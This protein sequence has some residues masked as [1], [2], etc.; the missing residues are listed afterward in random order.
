VKL[1]VDFHHSCLFESHQLT[2]GDRFGFEVYA[3]YGMDW[4]NEWIWSFEREWHGD[5]VAR[6]YL[7]GIFAGGTLDDGIM[8]VADQ[9]HPGRVIKGITLERAR[10]ERWDLVLSSV[11]SN[12]PGFEKF[13]REHGGRWGIHVGNQWG[14]EAWS[15]S[16]EFAILTTT[17]P[18]PG[19]IPHVVVHQEFSLDD[20]HYEPPAE[21]GPI[22]SFV[23]CFPEMTSEYQGNFVPLAR[24]APEFDWRVFGAYGTAPLDEFEGGNIPSDPLEGTMM[25][26][27]GVIWH[28]KA[29]SDG[30]GHVVHRAFA[31]GR[32]VFGY[33]D[34]YADKLAGPLWVDGVTSIDVGRRSQSEI[35][36][37]LRRL[38][39][40]P[41]AY[42]AMCEASAARFREVVSFD[43]DADKLADLLGLRVPA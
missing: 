23:N 31:V 43:E 13:A 33:Q 9:K 1:L 11:P 35:V 18:V 10:Q 22:R 36:A 29:W 19:G 3:P 2:F 6:Q 7:E 17:S 30:F 25:R 34:F 42:E 32:P 15:R 28:S 39:D 38:R 4:F 27:A 12:A 26:G 8:T 41:D 14:D 24:S 5:A 37:E 20:F 16:P 21:F 40:D